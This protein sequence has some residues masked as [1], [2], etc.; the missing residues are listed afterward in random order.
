M[1]HDHLWGAG[2]QGGGALKRLVVSL[3]SELRAASARLGIAL[4]RKAAA[5]SAGAPPPPGPPRYLRVNTLVS[6]VPAVVAELTGAGASAAG[7]GPHL[8][9]AD[10]VVDEHVPYVLRLLPPDAHRRLALH[11]HPLVVGRPG[12]AGGGARAGRGGAA[13]G[14]QPAAVILQDKSSCFTAHALLWDLLPPSLRASGSDAAA[15]GATERGGGKASRKRRRAAAVT[16]GPTA[17]HSDAPAPTAAEAAGRFVASTAA[18]PTPAVL[19]PAGYE[20]FFGGTGMHGALSPSSTVL[21]PDGR[22][23]IRLAFPGAPVFVRRDGTELLQLLPIDDG[24]GAGGFDGLDACAAPGNKT[25]QLAA[26]LAAVHLPPPQPQQ[27]PLAGDRESAANEAT[28]AA[29]AAWGEA[30][31][32]GTTAQMSPAAAAQAAALEAQRRERKQARRA[33]RRAEQERAFY[34]V[35]AGLGPSPAGDADLP[36][37]A[38]ALR[39]ACSD[40]SISGARV[41]AFDKSRERAAVLQSRVDAAGCGRFVTV[42]CADVVAA[43]LG[44]DAA[45]GRVRVA[46]VDP[47]CSGSGMA[48]HG[49]AADAE[50]A[51]VAAASAAAAE[52]GGPPPEPP[53]AEAARVASLAT[54]QVSGSGGSGGG[55]SAQ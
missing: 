52:A 9:P 42:T 14:G 40:G 1:L 36:S 44:A 18:A 21:A 46:V 20:L 12:A 48:A 23:R 22:S 50:G 55:V 19:I 35:G 37:S 2:V 7:S 33:A 6:S 38:P 49:G 8:S 34:G 27:Q 13:A 41:F 16:S 10:V 45:L 29:A 30:A 47:S 17:L 3:D 53:E 5:A 11:S 51:G 26:L 4:G 24:T 43:D 28:A 25:T 54:F 15:S 31:A 32:A 39:Q